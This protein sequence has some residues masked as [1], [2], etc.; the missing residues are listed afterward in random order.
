MGAVAITTLAGALLV[1]AADGAAFLR[2]LR[3]FVKGMTVAYWAMAT[4]WIPLLLVLGAWRHVSRRTPLRYDTEYWSMVFPLGMYT[5]ATIRFAESL[6]WPFLA[7][8]PRVV[9]AAALGAWVAAFIGFLRA[10]R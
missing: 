8:I 4:W 5:V 3:P 9:G 1:L 2:E 10:L 7:P 6:P